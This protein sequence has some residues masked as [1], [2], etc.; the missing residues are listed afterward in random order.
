MDPAPEDREER[1]KAQK[2]KSP[3]NPSRF[4]DLQSAVIPILKPYVRRISVFGSFARGESLPESDID[5]L[6]EL[7][8]REKRP[9]LGLKWFRLEI[10]LGRLLGKKIDLISEKDLSQRMKPFVEKDRVVLY[11]EE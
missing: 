11:E 6:V 3:H 2:M 8:P 9:I 5:L 7:K 4:E 10:E 1:K